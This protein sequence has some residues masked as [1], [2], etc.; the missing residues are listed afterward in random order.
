LLGLQVQFG[1]A[2]LGRALTS[3]REI[4]S[5]LDGVSPYREKV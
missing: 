3:S 5:G 2:R 1:R 4:E